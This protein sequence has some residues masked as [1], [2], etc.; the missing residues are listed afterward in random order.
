MNRNS[1]WGPWGVY[2]GGW[3]C[4]SSCPCHPAPFFSQGSTDLEPPA[5]VRSI[6]FI[7]FVPIRLCLSLKM[8]FPGGSADK[9]SACSAGVLVWSLGWENHL[10]KGMATHSNILAWRLPWTEEPGG[11]Q[12]M[13]SQRIRHDWVT[14]CL[15]IPFFTHHYFS[16]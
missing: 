3:N 15:V 1:V 5:G 12:S 9:E 4:C 11:L 10:E 14:V 13:G 2:W 16:S 7:L 6:P 8:G